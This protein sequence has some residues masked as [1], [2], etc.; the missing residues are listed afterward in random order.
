MDLISN[1][2]IGQCKPVSASRRRSSNDTFVEGAKM[3]NL[4]MVAENLKPAKFTLICALLNDFVRADSNGK[5]SDFI[6]SDYEVKA[7]YIEFLLR[8]ILSGNFGV[9]AL[10]NEDDGELLVTNKWY[11][12]TR[13]DLSRLY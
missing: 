2:V 4:K 12:L 7:A 6:L 13:R 3:V 5:R 8:Q 11:S 1:L 9:N 10:S